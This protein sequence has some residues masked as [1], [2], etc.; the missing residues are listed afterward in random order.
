VE[1]QDSHRDIGAFHHEGHEE[2][3]G[4]AVAGSV[5]YT[6][7]GVKEQDTWYQSQVWWYSSRNPV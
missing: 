7:R 2:H 6:P 1:H 5:Y 4:G 3:L